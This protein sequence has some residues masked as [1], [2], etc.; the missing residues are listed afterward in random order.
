MLFSVPVSSC[1]IVCLIGLS[2]GGDRTKDVVQRAMPT[3]CDRLSPMELNSKCSVSGRDPLGRMCTRALP[4]ADGLA[5]NS[6]SRHAPLGRRQQILCAIHSFCMT[7]E[8]PSL[9]KSGDWGELSHGSL[10]SSR[11]A[12]DQRDLSKLSSN[13]TIGLLY[14]AVNSW[15][16]ALEF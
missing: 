4:S 9:L 10:L 14:D 12:F 11:R 13:T 1:T 15:S 2:F 6:P 5:A 7:A 16:M 3:E 8:S